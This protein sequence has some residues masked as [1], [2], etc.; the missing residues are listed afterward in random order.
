MNGQVILM[1]E[2][3]YGLMRVGKCLTADSSKYV[4]ANG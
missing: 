2:A 3:Q 4:H 1:T